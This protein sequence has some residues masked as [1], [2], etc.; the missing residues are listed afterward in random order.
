M[1]TLE[2]LQNLLP[3]PYAVAGDAVLTGL[4]N[5]FAVE[6][7]VYQEDLDRLRQSHWIRTAYRLEDAAKLAA[8]VGIAPLSWENL[9]TFR[10]RLLPLVAARLQ[11]ALG[12]R[13][14]ERFVYDYLIN[15]ERVLDCLFIPGLQS[16]SFEDA[17]HPPVDRPL[18]RPLA[19]EENPRVERT[20]ATL[21][22]RGGQVPCLFRWQ[23]VNRGL[24]ETAPTFKISGLFGGRTSVPVLFNLSTAEMVG[25]AGTLR[26]GDLLTIAPGADPVQPGLAQALLNGKDVTPRLFSLRNATLGRPWETSQLD[27]KP[28][29]PH[30]AR[31]AN[32]WIFL[33]VGLYDLKGL[34]NFFFALAEARL[35]EGVFDSTFFDQALFPSGPLAQVE[36]AWEEREP[37]SFEVQVPRFLVAEPR[38]LARQPEGHPY[39]L[40]AQALEASIQDLHAAGVKAEVR[41][42]PFRETQEQA[43]RVQLPWVWLEPEKGPAGTRDTLDTGGL[44]GESPLGGSRFE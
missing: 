18:F 13:E 30:L 35:L 17:Y 8:L 43:V 20:S 41:L 12:P 22:A 44:F 14:I 27:E 40:V 36:M 38:F 25:Y 28:R 31:G 23:E 2:R 10:E 21:K 39:E 26:F 5:V 1:N 34:N 4:L 29:L 33:A 15:C 24:E 7:E 9:D 37:A 32:D 42:I 11:G 6:M 3:I 16:M 19:L